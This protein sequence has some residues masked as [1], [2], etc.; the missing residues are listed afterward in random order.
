MLISDAHGGETPV[1]ASLPN[2]KELAA[3]SLP[4]PL[5]SPPAL[6]GMISMLSASVVT[7]LI[8]VTLVLPTVPYMTNSFLSFVRLAGER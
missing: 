4:G 1:S 5:P 7:Q 8:S 3:Q 2:R 6:A